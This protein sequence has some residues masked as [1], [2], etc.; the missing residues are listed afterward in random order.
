[1]TRVIRVAVANQP[2]LMRESIATSLGYEEDIE[3]VANVSDEAEITGVIEATM[4][5]FLIVGLDSRRF[6]PSAREDTLQRHPEMKILAIA[7][8]GNSFTLFSA[9]DG[10]RSQIYKEP[11]AEILDVM[12][13]NSRG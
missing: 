10:V 3:I 6:G 13:T 11:E 8:D 5:E 4:P 12:R 9:S 1:M 2:R 7:S